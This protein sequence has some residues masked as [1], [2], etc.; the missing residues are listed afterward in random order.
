MTGRAGFAAVGGAGL[1][2]AW[3]VAGCGGAQPGADAPRAAGLPPVPLAVF[4]SKSC[5]RVHPGVGPKREGNVHQGSTVALARGRAGLVAYV[6]DHD[7][8][9][10][11][12][13][14]VA[15][16]RVDAFVALYGAPEQIEVLGDGRVV[17]AIGGARHL[18]AFE[19]T[20]D[21]RA[22][23][24]RLC[25]REVP[26]GP[27]A[28]ATSR[29]DTLLAVTS[30]WEPSL[31]VLDASL[32]PRAAVALPRAPRG[33]L[34]DGH[35]RAFVS[36][37]VGGRLSVV[38]LDDPTRTVR[39]ISLALRAGSSVGPKAALDVE[40]S[41]SQ[42]YA[43]VSVEIASPT[44]LTPPSRPSAEVPPPVRGVAPPAPQPRPA[45][46]NPS[47]PPAPPPPAPPPPAPPSS[48]F[49]QAPEPTPPAAADRILVPMVSVDPGDRDRPSQFYY[50]PPP[51]AGVP[52]QAPVAVVVDPVA[53]RSL[54]SHVLATTG[55]QRGA[56]CVLPRAVAAHPTE[57]LV[58]VACLGIDELLELDARSADPMRTVRRRFDVPKG[59]TG[60]AI[61]Q[62]EDVAVVFSQFDGAL[63]LVPLDGSPTQKID[64]GFGDVP[65][66]S[67]AMNP[68]AKRGRQLFYTA[69]DRRITS[70]GLA[71]SSCHPDGTED[72]L[73]W[74]TP[75]G[76]RQTPM[77]AGRLA[78]TQ[79]YGWTRGEHTL[80][81]YIA[82]TCSRLG[83]TGLPDDELDDLAAFVG[84]IPGPPRNSLGGPAL[85]REGKT[86]FDERG[87]GSCHVGA[88]GTDAKTHAFAGKEPVD[89]PSLKDVSLT[90]PYFHDGRYATLRDLLSDSS[91][92]MGATASLSPHE[93][94]AL[95]A[96]LGSL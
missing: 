21:A 68:V 52:K 53:G 84:Q 27:F 25:A 45:R 3:V 8:N 32:S 17:A 83:G 70:D 38:D 36:H 55:A 71:C 43:L 64:V 18:E 87:C 88:I 7:R 35:D 1:L 5:E 73:T 96:F 81:S 82:G 15:S 16:K 37:L 31:T 74:F 12:V 67:I 93:R 61:A 86:L 22:P 46:R 30:A 62:K 56:E 85:V 11:A 54:T 50:G 78:Q 60:V 13:V 75:D 76:P 26:A 72:G 47:P 33:V 57:Q 90:A 40:R 24:D 59:P 42:A 9:R 89:T 44:P 69:D 48:F 29:D 4:A 63:A 80:T 77:L 28:L 6:A 79:P 14:D 94:E 20:G 49:A 34:V 51:I 2:S 10:I 66:D 39:D 65:V 19:P 58:Y 91:S 41:G 95:L 92:D 23:L